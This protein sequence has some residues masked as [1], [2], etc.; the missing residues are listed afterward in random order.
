MLRSVDGFDVFEDGNGHRTARSSCA[1]G[2]KHDLRFDPKE[3]LD[4][5]REMKTDFNEHCSYVGY[6]DHPMV[7]RANENFDGNINRLQSMLD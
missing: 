7:F 2:R 4:K 5:Q 3:E 6:G 1:I